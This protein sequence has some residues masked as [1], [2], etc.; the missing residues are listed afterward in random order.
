MELRYDQ[1]LNKTPSII[2]LNNHRNK[3]YLTRACGDAK[4]KERLMV[5]ADITLICRHFV[6]FRC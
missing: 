4:L 1:R 6:H 3:T 5:I 2:A